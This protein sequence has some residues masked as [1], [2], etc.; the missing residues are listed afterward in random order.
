MLWKG[1]VTV[2]GKKGFQ[3]NHPSLL[4]DVAKTWAQEFIHWS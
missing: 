1:A 2:L 3:N 4:D